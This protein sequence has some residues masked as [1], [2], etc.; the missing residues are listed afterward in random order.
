MAL[1]AIDEVDGVAAGSL[2]AADP[3]GAGWFVIGADG[4]D[5]FRHR[6]VA[7][8]GF[9]GST[10]AP[11]GTGVAPCE[12]IPGAHCSSPMQSAQTLTIS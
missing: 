9:P 6:A 7:P 1:V 2:V 11:G 8:A 3:A 12:V 10:P 4:L 5:H